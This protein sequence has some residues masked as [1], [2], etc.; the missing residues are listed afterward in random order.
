MTPGFFMALDFGSQGLFSWL[1]LFL[2]VE[3]SP[4]LSWLRDVLGSFVVYFACVYFNGF[5][6]NLGSRASTFID[7]NLEQQSSWGKL[8]LKF[9]KSIAYSNFFLCC[10]GITS[11]FCFDGFQLLQLFMAWC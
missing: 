8:W 5:S 2:I 6:K 11:S 3:S 10:G 4:N 1:E 9:S 7:L